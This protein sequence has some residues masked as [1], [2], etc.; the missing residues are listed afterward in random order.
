MK[1]ITIG[2][3]VTSIGSLSNGI[4]NRLQ[5]EI[6]HYVTFYLEVYMEGKQQYL[7]DRTLL[8]IAGFL[9]VPIIIIDEILKRCIH[10]LLAIIQSC[11][12]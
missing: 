1:E 6:T 10:Y 4:F 3:S 9:F 8:W 12:L 5:V 7:T 11:Y 2:N